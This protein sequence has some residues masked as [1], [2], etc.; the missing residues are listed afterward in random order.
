MINE[1]M[2]RYFSAPYPARAVV[3]V[4]ALPRE[5]LVEVDGIMVLKEG[6]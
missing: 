3:E 1:T 2:A 4:A 5:A 6:R